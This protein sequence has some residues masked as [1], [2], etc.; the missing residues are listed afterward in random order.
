[1][2]KAVTECPLCHNKRHG[3]DKRGYAFRAGFVCTHNPEEAATKLAVL[4]L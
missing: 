1:M 2:E 3:L 4:I